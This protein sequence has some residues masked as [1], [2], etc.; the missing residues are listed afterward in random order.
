MEN[1]TELTPRLVG[2]DSN[3]NVSLHLDEMTEGD[4]WN[5]AVDTGNP[6]NFAER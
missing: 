2:N 6:S 5:L 1:D 3:A 4:A